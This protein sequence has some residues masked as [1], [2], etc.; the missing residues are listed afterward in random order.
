LRAKVD[1]LNQKLRNSQELDDIINYHRSSPI[2]TSLGYL[3]ESS[4]SID[5]EKPHLNEDEEKPHVEEKSLPSD[6]KHPH[7]EKSY[8]EDEEKP[9][10]KEEKKHHERKCHA[11]NGEK[12]KVKVPHKS[13]NTESQETNVSRNQDDA[14][15]TLIHDRA[16]RSGEK[17]RYSQGRDTFKKPSPSTPRYT[18]T[19]HDYCYTCSNYGHRARDYGSMDKGFYQNRRDKFTGRKHKVT[20]TFD[21]RIYNTFTPLFKSYIECY[22]CHNLGHFARD[23]ESNLKWTLQGRN[24]ECYL[25]HEFGHFAQDCIRDLIWTPQNQEGRTLTRKEDKATRVW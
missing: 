11:K 24:A 7:E 3:G 5:E 8:P 23:C 6:E 1:K 21:N 12:P 17:Q 9:N 2:K 15:K 4:H 18:S 20:H 16:F 14:F 19:F 25:Y 13:T 22:I 10:V